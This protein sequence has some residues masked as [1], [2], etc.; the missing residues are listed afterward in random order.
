L[1]SCEFLSYVLRCLKQTL[2]GYIFAN[3]TAIK[4]AV[5]VGKV[6]HN[7]IEQRKHHN[8]RSLESYEDLEMREPVRV[9]TAMSVALFISQLQE[10][11]L[12]NDSLK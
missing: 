10:G 11:L 2:I 12:K 3:S 7:A 5:R 1:E 4:A 6:A 8:R 9:K